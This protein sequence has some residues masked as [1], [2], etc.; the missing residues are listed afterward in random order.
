MEILELKDFFEEINYNW[1]KDFNKLKKIA[2]YTKT[3]WH[4]YRQQFEQSY[5]LKGIAEYYK[6]E[7]FLEIGTGRGA[8]CYTLSLIP[9]IK[10]I[11]TV[12][13]IPFKEK[14]DGSVGWERTLISIEDTYN[15]IPFE[16]KKKI[17]FYER[18]DFL[19][20][21]DTLPKFDM[22]FIDG[23]HD[24]E[25]IIREDFDICNKLIKDKG[26]ILFDDYHPKK[27]K[28]KTVVDRIIKEYDFKKVLLIRFNGRL[29]NTKDV[30]AGDG[31]I[32]L[33]K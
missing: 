33:E 18:K 1:K 22:C 20:I 24:N 4:R 12:D 9:N 11:V 7:S 17:K 28:V 3:K 19:Q 21:I 30:D 14:Q 26:I 27:Y 2:Y 15:L 25:S 10:N 6:I 23:D 31:L 8:T 29:F 16:E 5:L 32:L 13:I